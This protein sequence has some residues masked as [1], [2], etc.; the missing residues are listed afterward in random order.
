MKSKMSSESG[1][2]AGRSEGPL[3]E[4]LLEGKRTFRFDQIT[5]Q[6]KQKLQEELDRHNAEFAYTGKYLKFKFDEEASMLYVEVIDA[7]TH[8]VIV[9]L[10]PEFLIDLS[11]KMKKILG[12]YI[13]ERL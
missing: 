2:V 8:E 7:S 3:G 9:S 12:L 1:K 11:I 6:D 10:P 4:R 13:D 5:E